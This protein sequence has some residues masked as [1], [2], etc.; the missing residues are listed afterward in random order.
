[1]LSDFSVFSVAQK[2]ANNY[3]G[4]KVALYKSTRVDKKYMIHDGKKWIH[5][6]Q[7]GYED[8]TKHNDKKRRESY[9]KRS[10]NIPGNWASNPFSPNNL[11]RNI[12]W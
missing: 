3:F 10:A 11:S 4:K 2:N 8:F 9:L 5:F 1:M 7:M 6:G 12:L